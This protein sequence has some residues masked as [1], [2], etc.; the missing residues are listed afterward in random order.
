I[1]DFYR[2]ESG[3]R[4]RFA[5]EVLGGG[6]DALVSARADLVIAAPGDVPVTGGYTTRLLGHVDWVFA[7]APHHPLA[8]LPEPLNREQILVHRAVAVADSSR[9]LTPRTIGV[10][11]GQ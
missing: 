10:L 4:L 6:W 1:D 8:A 5:A 3:T 2:E 11:S 9:S 7:V